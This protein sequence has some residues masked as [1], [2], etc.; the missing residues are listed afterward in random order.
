MIL[1]P[2]NV[3]IHY[4]VCLGVCSRSP[5]LLLSRSLSPERFTG[6]EHFDDASRL[7]T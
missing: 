4:R 2:L 3:I 6:H 1:P 7:A 5:H